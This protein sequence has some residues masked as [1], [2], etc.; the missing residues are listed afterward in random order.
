MYVG[1]TLLVHGP[2]L[3]AT[4]SN[5]YVLT[6]NALNLTLIGVAWVMADSLATES[7]RKRAQRHKSLSQ[8]QAN[9][10]N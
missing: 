8:V 2:M 3:V 7:S 5:H 1:F 4:P 9:P 6:E 10:G